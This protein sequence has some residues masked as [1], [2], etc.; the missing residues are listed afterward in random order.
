[1]RLTFAVTVCLMM[2]LGLAA[3][4]AGDEWMNLQVNE[5][6]RLPVHTSFLA[7]DAAPNESSRYLSLDG[8]WKF[9]WVANLDERPTDFYRTDLD[10]SH[11]ATMPVPGMWE[12]NGYGDPIYLNIGF[13]WRGNWE[14]DPPHVPVQDNHVGTY[15][16]HITLPADWHGKQ[17][18]AHF[19]SVT[20]NIN[21]WVNGQFAGYAEDS[22]TAA[23]FDITPYL[24]E[25][26][27]LLAFQVMRWCDG[28]YCED[29]DFWR[30]SGVA[31]SSYLY[32]RD[33]NCHIDDIRVTAGLTDNFKDGTLMVAPT[34]TGKGTLSYHLYDALGNEVTMEP[35]GENRWTISAPHQWT[36]ETPYLYS[37]IA[38]LTPADKKST[39][40]AVTIKVGFR[41]VEIKDG[42][43]LVNGKAVYIKG[44][45]RHEMDPDGGY[46]VSRDRMIADI[47]EMKRMNINAVR[48]CHYSD[49]PQWYDLCD[50][51]GLYVI[52]EA[53]MESHGFYY[54]PKTAPTYQ[55][56]FAKQILE[57][58]Q[59][60]VSVQFNHPSVIVWSLG[61]ETCDG[62]NFTAA[63]DWI[64]ANDPSRPIHWERALGG[65]NTDLMCPMYASPAWCERYA[66][67]PES[68]K[69]L[70]LC[71]YNHTMGN[72]GGGL[73]EYWDLVRRL[74]KF[75]GG[76]VWDFVDQGLRVKTEDSK[77]YYSYGGDYNTHD[78]SDNNFNCNG[79]V[80]PD[81]KWNPH[82][83]ETAYYYQSVW[84]EDV[85][86]RQG[87]I[88]VR[89]EFF[90]RDLSN[91]K[92]RWQLL[93]D[94]QS[95]LNG[96][97]LNL[98]VAP[99]GRQALH[100]PIANTLAAL[101]PNSEVMLN[102]D[103]MLKEAE[104]LMESGQRIAY[105]QLP[106]NEVMPQATHLPTEKAKFIVTQPKQG[107]LTIS[108]N[109][110]NITFDGKTGLITKYIV[111]GV[112]ILGEGGTLRPN[113]WR[114]VT[115][116]DMGA[117]LQQKL[118]VWRNPVM[119]LT[120]LAVDKKAS[121]KS[122]TTVVAR[123]DMP[124]VAATLTLTYEIHAGGAMCVT[125]GIAFS[126]SYQELPEMLRFGIVM[127]L[128]YQ[129]DISDFYGRGPIEN[130]ADRRYSQRLGIY[131]QTADEQF[132]PYIR[133]QETGTKGDIR[134]WTQ[135]D[136]QGNGIKVTADK[137][138]Y[139]SALH[140]DITM[141]DEGDEKHQRH[142][143]DLFRSMYTVLTLDS[144][145][146]GVGGIDSW[147][148]RPL[149]Q[150]RLPAIDRTCSFTI[151][152]NILIDSITINGK[153]YPIPS[154]GHKEWEEKM[155]DLMDLLADE[156]FNDNSLDK[157]ELLKS[158]SDGCVSESL[159]LAFS[160][161]LREQPQE[162]LSSLYN[163]RDNPPIEF[164]DEIKYWA[165]ELGEEQT[166]PDNDLPY[167]YPSMGFLRQEIAKLPD[168]N[169]QNYLIKLFD[170]PNK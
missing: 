2:T 48:T 74:P 98:N 152:P 87:D 153:R 123:Y 38:M 17:I 160:C 37:L 86:V 143:C 105:A 137:P 122:Q 59:H 146:C 57:R 97:E 43:L 32:C 19:G 128:P 24:K 68:T 138:F 158:H 5:I 113:F 88:A 168:K 76:F 41:R 162:V 135:T 25:G 169:A 95:V 49:D 14:N 165:Q 15:R 45:N 27:N 56:M 119:N 30:L 90:F 164:I 167:N 69:P 156:K 39:G 13:P 78:P 65:E 61:N 145:Q 141:L 83:Y 131:R 23:E 89:N 124:E 159:S 108:G 94:G 139:A 47:K 114:A 33:K 140:Y 73:M 64:R 96:E 66:S 133:P 60:N 107:D 126:D 103:F 144:E 58:N 10:D 80:S 8:D 75:Q 163:H 157:W 20:S 93:V 9:H 71:E 136:D 142:P 31:R 130:Y 44:A 1:M 81:R 54:D 111:N 101:D 151:V 67:K 106:I 4:P 85:N 149:E 118:K 134:W 148:A 40:E 120:S 62:P 147:G 82:A 110:I 21:L 22:K 70:I 127:E 129:M 63:R 115:D 28:T 35:T 92:M 109:D 132:Y 100:L 154:W 29:Q 150:Y 77:E 166:I 46:V 52:A 12:L 91:V 161:V 121:N 7:Y 84:A 72:S 99:Q 102:V 125:Q 16:R 42:Q 55:P 112:P 53:N 26:D 3:Q 117:G 18:I 170:I 50:E 104:P 11:W 116:N 36:A 79:L 6:N 34:L 51:Y 155:S